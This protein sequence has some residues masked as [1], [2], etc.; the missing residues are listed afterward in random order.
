MSLSENAPS[1]NAVT[2][3]DVTKRMKDLNIEGWSS[4]A[5]FSPEEHMQ[6][7]DVIEALQKG[8]HKKA[9]E[10]SG[11]HGGVTYHPDG[12]ATYG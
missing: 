3:D 1:G 9:R 8:N 12:G 4:M 5:D 10:L 7:L 2:M 6:H 11:G